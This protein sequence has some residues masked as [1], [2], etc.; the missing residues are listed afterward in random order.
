MYKILSFLSL[1]E[2]CLIISKLL[3]AQK[4]EIS[5]FTVFMSNCG[6]YK[7]GEKLTKGPHQSPGV[8]NNRDNHTILLASVFSSLKIQ[9]G[10]F[11][12]NG[13]PK[14]PISM[15]TPHFGFHMSKTKK[16]IILD[17]LK[18]SFSK[19]LQQLKDTKCNIVIKRGAQK[20]N[21]TKQ[22]PF[23]ISFVKNKVNNT[24]RLSKAI[25]SFRKCLQQ[26]KDPKCNI[27]FYKG[28]LENQFF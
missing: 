3:V 24:F 21:I 26:L 2:K 13:P 17:Y 10:T 22:P 12:S 28:C 20:S 14:N 27:F 11:L 16:M 5:L 4:N 25:S 15:N 1:L 9:N 19:C 18:P 6:N 7:K 8:C 23:W